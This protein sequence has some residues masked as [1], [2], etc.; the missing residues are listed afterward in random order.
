VS[1][2]KYSVTSFGTNEK[3]IGYPSTLYSKCIIARE[4]SSN[5]GL[6]EIVRIIAKIRGKDIIWAFV[7]GIESF[8]ELADAVMDMA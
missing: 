1:L 2:D 5:C 7:R 8:G 4:M 3:A 6:V